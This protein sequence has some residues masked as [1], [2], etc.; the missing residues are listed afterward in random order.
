MRIIVDVKQVKKNWQFAKLLAGKKKLAFLEKSFYANLKIPDILKLKM[1]WGRGNQQINYLI[2]DNQKQHSGGIA[3]SKKCIDNAPYRKFN[4]WIPI[5]LLDNREGLHY[6]EALSLARYAKLKG[7]IVKAFS[8][9]GCINGNVPSNDFIGAVSQCLRS[10][11]SYY[12]IGGS[13]VL[14]RKNLPNTV[15]EIRIGDYVL[16]GNIPFTN[17]SKSEAAHAVKLGLNVIRYYSDRNQYLLRGGNSIYNPE[18][19][20][21]EDKSIRIVQSSSEYTIIE[22]NKLLSE[23]D[24]VIIKTD[25]HSLQ[26]MKSI[27]QIN[28]VG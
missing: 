12:S 24:E 9:I 23:G 28:Y 14:N 2:G 26:K 3:V 20:E 6:T 5:N 16:F 11:F 19:S 17:Q 21:A 8:T 4:F 1:S 10:E 15:D 25:Y 7:H 13:H 22:T 27:L 18:T